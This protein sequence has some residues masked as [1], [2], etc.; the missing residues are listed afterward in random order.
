MA[1][2]LLPVPAGLVL[3]FVYARRAVG[4]LARAGGLRRAGGRARLR[5]DGLLQAAAAVAVYA[6]GL[7]HVPG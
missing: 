5:A 1:F 3:P 6:W 7:L 4:V 2:L